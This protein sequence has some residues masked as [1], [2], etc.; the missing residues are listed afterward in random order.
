VSNG[1]RNVWVTETALS[2]ALNMSYMAEQLSLFSIIIGVALVLAGLGFGILAIGGA[3]RNP[4]TALR[5]VHRRKVASSG[6]V[7]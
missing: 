7:S 5:F 2:T 6:A 4:D 3:L 1:A